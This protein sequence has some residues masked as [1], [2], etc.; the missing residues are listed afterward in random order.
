[1]GNDDA[2]DDRDSGGSLDSL[3]R[4]VARADVLEPAAVARRIGSRVGRFVLL[5]ELGRGGMGVVY[6]AHD[7]SLGRDIALKVLPANKERDA[8]RRARF[9]REARSAGSVIHSNVVVVHEVGEDDG[10]PFIAMELV[11]GKSLRDVLAGGS[12]APDEVVRLARGIAK[13]L[14]AAH[15]R[16]VIHRDLKP[17]NVIV[18][19][20]GVP[21][22]LDFGLAKL[23]EHD[24]AP[25]ETSTQNEP[26]PALT[27]EEGHVLGTPSY[28]SPEQ[29]AGRAADARTDLFSLGV[30]LYEALSGARPFLGDSSHEIVAAVLRDDP[31][32]LREARPDVP[33]RLAAIVMRCL[34]KSPADRFASAD[35]LLAALDGIESTNAGVAATAVP[36]AKRRWMLGAGA[37]VAVGV[38]STAL[39]LSRMNAAPSASSPATAPLK[40]TDAPMPNSQNAAALAAYRAGLQDLHDGSIWTGR[41][42]MARAIALDPSF[43]AAYVRDCTFRIT[44]DF[45]PRPCVVARQQRSLLSE[46][47]RAIVD[48][49]EPLITSDTP[50]FVAAAARGASIAERYPQDA[51]IALYAAMLYLTAGN[52]TELRRWCDRALALDPSFAPVLWARERACEDEACSIREMETCLRVSPGAATCSR[53]L[54]LTKAKSGA[55]DEYDAISRNTLAMEPEGIG[56][57]VQRIDALVSS[58]RPRFE[59][60]PLFDAIKKLSGGL[61]EPQRDI[62]PPAVAAHYGAFAEAK[63]K[64]AALSR[65]RY[66]LEVLLAEE[67]RD[68]QASLEAAQ[69]LIA[70]HASANGELGWDPE[71]DGLAL[72]VARRAGAI[73][74]A[75]L[76]AKRKAW[77]EQMT[78]GTTDVQPKWGAL[79]LRAASASSPEE[80]RAVLESI[81]CAGDARGCAP[82]YVVRLFS[83]KVDAIVGHAA[84][85]AGHVDEALPLLERTAKTCTVTLLNEGPG[86]F[87]RVHARFELAEALAKKGDVA[88]A[89]EWYAKVVDQW[90]AA[91][92]PSVTAENARARMKALACGTKP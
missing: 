5:E 17:E 82:P 12:M 61:E 22:I 27:T 65:R 51:E 81:G 91:K 33:A 21:K 39:A 68:R 10:S 1:L 13:G 19:D 4:E 55:C 89:C 38:A 16:G 30:V 2:H 26:A 37:L 63:E 75:E 45:T 49:V 73:S 34:E 77:V 58:G 24:D 47:D 8:N 62:T 25:R 50:D 83:I 60:T 74:Q 56:A 29:A 69:A 15:A 86:V 84:L 87:T 42:L 78:G 18:N 53:T 23:R 88:G 71:G 57:R 11:P 48:L 40:M 70:Q 14:A 43:A 59:T 52:M 66:G 28:M 92:P 76:D 20:E 80:A 3:L 6:R 31:P 36:P 32:P 44:S 9:L 90:G 64:L 46:R 67:T 79:A 72:L 7:E 85:L 54:G 35:E 41:Q